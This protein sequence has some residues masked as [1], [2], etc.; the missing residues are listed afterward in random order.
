MP[1]SDWP[2]SGLRALERQAV[3]ILARTE[4]L[5]REAFDREVGGR[6]GI[7][8]RAAVRSDA[9]WLM[10]MRWLAQP[11]ALNPLLGRVR[12]DLERIGLPLRREGVRLD[13]DRRPLKEVQSFCAAIRVPE[14]VVLVISPLGGQTDARSLMHEIG[15]AL[16]FTHTSPSLP[17]EDRALGDTLGHGDV[18]VALRVP[19][20]RPGVGRHRVG[21]GRCHSGRVSRLARFLHLYRLRRQPRVP[22]RDWRSRRRTSRAGWHPATRSC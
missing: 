20:P 15:H 18:R 22:V 1:A 9:L 16:H 2:A 14:D 10:G 17:W 3:E 7:D 6:L 4:T 8:P 12:Q 21:S 11:F 19:H 13:F 5:Y